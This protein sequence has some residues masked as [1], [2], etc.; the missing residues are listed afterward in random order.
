VLGPEH[1]TTLGV[2]NNIAFCTGQAGD[3]RGALRLFDELLPD[4]ERVLGT[5]HQATRDARATISRYRKIARRSGGR[6]AP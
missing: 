1:P 2:R 5:H 4:L 3:A 6:P